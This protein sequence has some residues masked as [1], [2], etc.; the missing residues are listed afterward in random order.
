MLSIPSDRA[1]LALED[2][3]SESPKKANNGLHMATMHPVITRDMPD[4]WAQGRD[5]FSNFESERLLNNS[6]SKLEASLGS[7]SKLRSR[8]DSQDIAE[9]SRREKI[10][11]SEMHLSEDNHSQSSMRE[12]NKIFLESKTDQMSVRNRTVT[13]DKKFGK[14]SKIDLTNY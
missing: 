10:K 9:Y 13:H 11:N 6:P 14:K 7:L 3:Q 12:K 8:K 1:I 2:S 4:P 5:G